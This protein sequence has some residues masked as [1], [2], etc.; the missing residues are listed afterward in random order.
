MKL[1]PRVLGRRIS[2]IVFK[3]W[4][5]VWDWPHG[6]MAWFF[7]NYGGLYRIGPI[8]VHIHGAQV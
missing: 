6:R 1:F 4:S 3:R 7:W 8:T 5:V 2:A